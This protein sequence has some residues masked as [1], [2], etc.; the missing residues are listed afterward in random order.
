MIFKKK[1]LAITWSF[2]LFIFSFLSLVAKPKIIVSMTTIDSRINDIKPVVD[3]ILQQTLKPDSFELYLSDHP[4]LF[5]GGIDNGIPPEK[6][7]AFL[8][9]YERQGV[10]TITYVDN[11]GPA[12]KLLP[13]LK[14]NWGTDNIIITID[15]DV[16]YAPSFIATLYEYY[17]KEQCVI[18]AEGLKVSFKDTIFEKTYKKWKRLSLTQKHIYHFPLGH[19]GCLYTPAFFCDTVLDSK[20][21]LR[22]APTA[23]DVWFYFMRLVTKTPAVILGGVSLVRSLRVGDRSKR[24]IYI[25]ETQEVND[26]AICNVAAWLKDNGLCED[27]IK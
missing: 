7:P 21:L 1:F 22:L 23:D 10:L 16:Y 17:Q 14:D 18:A 4:S 19:G 12:N 20:L 9:D 8:R 15:D 3:S 27:I 24:L 2:V 6:V 5:E 26:G 11:I 25:N 13:C